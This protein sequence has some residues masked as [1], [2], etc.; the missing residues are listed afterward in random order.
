MYRI[1]G[2]GVD[3][4][5]LHGID[6][7]NLPS[8][9][10]RD[11]LADRYTFDNHFGGKWFRFPRSVFRLPKRVINKVVRIITNIHY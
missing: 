7:N 11:T 3:T 8:F 5:V 6:P 4:T 2:K 10:L 9:I 1:T